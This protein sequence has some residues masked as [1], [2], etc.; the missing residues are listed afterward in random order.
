MRRWARR[1]R[2]EKQSRTAKSATKGTEEAPAA[3]AESSE[4]VR[5]AGK[6]ERAA[7]KKGAGQDERPARRRTEPAAWTRGQRPW[8]CRTTNSRT[9]TLRSL[10]LGQ[11]IGRG[12]AAAVRDA[13]QHLGDAQL[14]DDVAGPAAQGDDGPPARLVADF[15]IAPTDAA[16]PA[17]AQGLENRL[18]GGP[19]AGEVLRGQLAALAVLNL[20]RRVDPVDEQLA[21]PLDHLRDAQA[22]DDVG[23]DAD[24]VCHVGRYAPLSYRGRP[25]VASTQAVDD[26]RPRDVVSIGPASTTPA[27]AA[28]RSAK[29]CG[30]VG[31]QSRRRRDA[32]SATER[33][34]HGQFIFVRSYACRWPM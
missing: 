18:L 3:A 31:P 19:A 5:K 9:L 8:S 34:L 2:R 12:V 17:G 1:K 6:T 33:A 20:V 26:R 21:V 30:K 24:D 13:D 25:A 32:A 27:R 22:F 4:P 15:D 11:G 28:R 29:Y 14:L 16:P 10:A 23:A 7:K